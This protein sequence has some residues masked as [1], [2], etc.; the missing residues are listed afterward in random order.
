M[1]I[2]KRKQTQRKISGYQWERE[3]G[4]DKIEV[5]DLEVQTTMYNINKL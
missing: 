4:R 5:G 3:A 2:T 1:N